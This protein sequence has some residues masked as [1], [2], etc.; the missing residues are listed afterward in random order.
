MSPE[1]EAAAV[2]AV[3]HDDNVGRFVRI[4][5]IDSGLAVHGWH[6]VDTVPQKLPRVVTVGMWMGE[7]DEAVMVGGSHD[8]SNNNWGE[9]QLILKATITERTW[10]S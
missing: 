9:C 3:Q 5:W 6:S 10:L 7:S 8:V 2:A 4:D 1:Q